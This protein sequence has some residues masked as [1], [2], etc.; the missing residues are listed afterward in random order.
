MTMGTRGID[1]EKAIHAA[2]GAVALAERTD[3]VRPVL[4][5]PTAA[6]T[7]LAWDGSGYFDTGFQ[8]KNRIVKIYGH[9]HV[10]VFTGLLAGLLGTLTKTE[11]FVEDIAKTGENIVKIMKRAKVEAF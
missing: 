7:M 10:Q 1:P 8:A 3:S 6:L 9:L 2:D 5:Q 11:K 4:S